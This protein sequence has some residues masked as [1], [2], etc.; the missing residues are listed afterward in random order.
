M[1]G[2]LAGW[3]AGQNLAELSFGRWL[4]GWLAS[5]N[6]AELNFGQK[7]CFTLHL[8]YFGA[9]ENLAEKQLANSS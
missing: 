6:L 8:D 7:L 2:W 9:F 5:E 3:M 1:A 4:A